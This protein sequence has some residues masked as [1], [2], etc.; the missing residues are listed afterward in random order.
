MKNVIKLV[1][2]CFALLSTASV[3]AATITGS[4]GV[5]DPV[6]DPN[7]EATGGL[8]I[9][10]SDVTTLDFGAGIQATIASGTFLATTIVD[11][12]ITGTGGVLNLSGLPVGGIKGFLS[13]GG[14]EFDLKTLSIDKQLAG[15]LELSGTG[16]VYSDSVAGFT[17]TQAN[18]SFSAVS[19][20]TYSMTVTA[21]PVPAAVWLFGSG[22][23]GLVG[24]A[25]R[26]A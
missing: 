2:A 26:K 9:D 15:T 25:R 22:L 23:L 16:M 4:F 11:E 3:Y 6:N 8:G 1:F 19:R 13:I 7:E 14:W 18:W 5:A 21:V 10:M 24:V 12:S 20:S 17:P